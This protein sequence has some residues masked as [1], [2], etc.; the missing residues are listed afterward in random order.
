MFYL[1]NE[2]WMQDG[3]LNCPSEKKRI[4]ARADLMRLNGKFCK[5]GKVIFVQCHAGGGE[6]GKA[7]LGY[8]ADIFGTNVMGYNVA[9]Y[10]GMN[11]LQQPLQ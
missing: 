1:T 5:N 10:L 6:S 7:G 11:G 8:L 4:A 3:T 2:I 9:Y